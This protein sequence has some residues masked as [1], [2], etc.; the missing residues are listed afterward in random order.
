MN[1]QYG[2]VTYRNLEYEIFCFN[3]FCGTIKAVEYMEV[4]RMIL[5]YI[6]CRRVEGTALRTES[7][8]VMD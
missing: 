8:S 3:F 5:G 2:S 4:V 6:L 1:K 7:V